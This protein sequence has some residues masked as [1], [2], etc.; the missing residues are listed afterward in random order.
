MCINPDA[1]RTM[2]MRLWIGLFVHFRDL[3]SLE[4]PFI[5]NDLAPHLAPRTRNT[6]VKHGG[7]GATHPYAVTY[8]CTLQQ[9]WFF[10]RVLHYNSYT[11]PL[12][13]HIIPHILLYF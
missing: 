12:F 3:T 4:K 10:K 13:S 9:K 11:I 6:H 8:I 2:R 5:Y 7:A 1:V